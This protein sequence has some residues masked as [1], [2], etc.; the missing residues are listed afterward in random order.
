MATWFTRSGSSRGGR[1]HA[2]PGD[3]G[4]KKVVAGGLHVASP[5]R[6]SMTD[7]NRDLD[8]AVLESAGGRGRTMRIDDLVSVVERHHPEG[9]GVDVALVERYVEEIAKDQKPEV[10][11][12]L[13][14]N[15]RDDRTDER[16]WAGSGYV[17]EV[18]DGRVSAFPANWHDR[19]DSDSDLTDV[20]RVIRADVDDTNEAFDVGGAGYGVPQSV[21]LEAAAAI[22]HVGFEESKA[23][24]DG[25][26]RNGVFAID[27]DQHPQGR[28][29]FTDEARPEGLDPESDYE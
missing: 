9:V 10:A 8:D 22:G 27:A 2:G 18:G 14:A 1:K 15:L 4:P 28:V 23:A 26:R 20:L 3:R 7:P 21:L 29:R 11:D 5:N 16:S 6:S 17:Y 12:R 24:V 13:E 25:Y 19:L